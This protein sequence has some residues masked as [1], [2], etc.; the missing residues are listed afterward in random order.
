MGNLASIFELDV[1]LPGIHLTDP[2]LQLAK[3]GLFRPQPDSPAIHAAQ[4]EFANIKLDIDGQPRE[5]KYDIGCDQL[6][7]APITNRT[8]TFK[9]VGPSWSDGLSRSGA[10]Q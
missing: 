2:K 5:G 7:V 6:S 9:D 4:G 8:L 1:D 3:D 10:D